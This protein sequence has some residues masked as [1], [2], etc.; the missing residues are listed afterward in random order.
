MDEGSNCSTS[1]PTLFTVCL[2]NCSH[3]NGC[4]VVISLW[5]DLNISL[6]TND[7]DLYISDAIHLYIV[8]EKYF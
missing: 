1:L 4:K 2:F 3:V 5:F 6:V 8:L 7:G